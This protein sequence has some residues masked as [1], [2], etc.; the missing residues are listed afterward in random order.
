V[1]IQIEKTTALSNY[2]FSFIQQHNVLNKETLQFSFAIKITHTGPTKCKN[3]FNW[4]KLCA[5]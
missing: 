1:H 2:V 3:F 4:Y 5:T